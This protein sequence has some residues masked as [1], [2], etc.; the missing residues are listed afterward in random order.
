MSQVIE[1]I[2]SD[3]LRAIE[4][5]SIVL[6]TLPEVALE[7]RQAASDP[8]VN[9]AM[10]AT[11]IEHDSS[12][13]AR[14][15]RVSNSSLLRGNEPIADVKTA[16]S[17]IGL[18]Y[19]GTLVTTLAMQQIFLSTNDSL[20]ARMRAL[21]VHCSDIAA[22]C[23]TLAKAQR[24]LRPEL[25]TLAGIV[26][27]IGALPLLSYAVGRGYLRDHP[28]LL[29][30]ALRQLAPEMGGRILASWGFAPALVAVPE[31]HLNFHRQVE[32]ADYADLV[33]VANLQNYVGT[34]H[35]LAAVDWSTV[36]AFARLDLPVIAGQGDAGY[37]EQVE[38]M[39]SLLR[40]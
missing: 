29:D 6:P 9:I 17:R 27:Q 7:I 14:I 25:A 30:Q 22:I 8:D 19:T 31:A 5:D 1:Q 39:Q 35:P 4:D 34:E 28:Q 32:K 10:L 11:I 33:T 3:M 12:L 40:G 15:I 13:A 24:H 38:Q 18:A 2:R 21:W 23:H 36:T 26:H 37:R 20:N 16:I